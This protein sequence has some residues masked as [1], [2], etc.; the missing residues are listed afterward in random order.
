M[1]NIGLTGGIAAGKS[2]I[3]AVFEDLG[4]H[5]IDAD[6]LARE[7]V[8]PGTEGLAQVVAAFGEH[9]LTDEGALD[10]PALGRVVFADD[11]ARARLGSIV[12]PLVA[13]RTA[14]LMAQVPQG[15]IVVHDVPLIVENRLADRYHLV[16]VAGADEAVRAERLVR[17]RGMSE[18]DAWARIRAQAD[19]D[20]RQTV[21]DVWLDTH[22]PKAQVRS[23]VEEL[24]RSRLVPFAQNIAANQPAARDPDWRGLAQPPEPPRTWP[25][26]A[27]CLLARIRWH[28]RE[29][30]R[31]ANHIGSTAV[32]G[33]PAKDVIDLQLGVEDLDAAVD[34]DESLRAAGYILRPDID[35]DVPRPHEPD[36]S[37]WRKR[38]YTN[39][40]PGRPVNLHVR[41]EGSPGWRFALAFRDWLI[42]DAHARDDYARVKQVLAGATARAE[43]YARAKEP[44]FT[45]ADGR[46]QAWVEQTGWQPH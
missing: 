46:L 29:G 2:T 6:V 21:A 25:Q 34:L 43:D 23:A 30:I 14:E 1:L 18:E 42:A 16:I 37:S 24:W 39:A 35:R 13:R 20:A 9:L 40:D 31:T 27:E 19:D 3:A 36:P 33:L 11:A 7:V 44:W 32:P 10:R 28:V 45:E 8:E 12:H 15:Q 26:Q 22:A 4:A 5:L 17:T 38:L 41:Q